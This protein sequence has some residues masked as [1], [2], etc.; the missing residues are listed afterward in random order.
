MYKRILLKLSGE[1]LAGGA[2]FGIDATAILNLAKEIKSIRDAGVEIGLI[3][4]GGNIHRGVSGESWGI[5]RV[6]SDHMG[7]LGTV[8]NGLAMQ[9]ALEGL[10]VETRLCSAVTLKSMT[11]PFIIRKVSKHLSKGRVV[12]LSGGTGNP[13]FTTDTAAALRASEIGAEI[14]LK[15]TKV[16][17]IYDKDPKKFSDAKKFNKLSYTEII[18]SGLK[19]MD[20]TAITLCQDNKIK[21]IVFNTLINGNMMKVV[22]G[23]NIGTLVE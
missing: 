10:G 12:I 22:Q 8:I 15:A 19:V 23:D 9:D 20:A 6:T 21:I 7:M 18:T 1:V 14:I 3:I 13:Y 2:S 17:G 11:E 5:S 16:D 4:G